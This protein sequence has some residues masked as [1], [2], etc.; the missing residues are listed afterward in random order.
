MFYSDKNEL[1]SKKIHYILVINVLFIIFGPFFVFQNMN[2]NLNLIKNTMKKVIFYVTFFITMC[3]TAQ[4]KVGSVYFNNEDVFGE[5]ELMLNGAG[6]RDKLYAIALYLDLDFDVDN[7]NDGNKVADKDTNMAITIKLTSTMEGEELRQVIR[8]GMERATDGNSYVLEDQIRDFINLIPNE[9]K[10]FDIFRILHK[11]GGDITVF[12]NKTKVGTLKSLD[13]KKALFK[14]WLGDNPVDGTL[15]EN[16][17]SSIDP[18]PVLGKWKTFDAK[19]GVAINI[20]QVYMIKNQVFATIEKMLRQSQRDDICYDC[21]GEDKNQKVE[22]LVIVKGLKPVG[23]N[24]YQGGT[25]TNIKDGSVSD[26]QMWVEEGNQ[27]I[28]KVKYKGSRD[29]HEWKRVKDVKENK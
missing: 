29:I 4:T 17:L 3:T 20:V 2:M 11:K 22:G 23:D 10:K 8:N 14:I 19:T 12:K 28:L 25:Y 18:N 6:T 16:L 9:V 13:F 15:K 5:T 21:V 24:K 26:C 27:G 1:L 7:L